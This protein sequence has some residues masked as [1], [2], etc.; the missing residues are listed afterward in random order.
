M[1][2]HHDDLD[3]EGQRLA[4]LTASPRE[5]RRATLDTFHHSIGRLALGT[6]SLIAF[7]FWAVFIAV[8]LTGDVVWRAL[9]VAVAA[10]VGA[11]CAWYG[12]RRGR[13]G[14]SWLGLGLCFAS[15]ALTR[16]LA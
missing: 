9:L 16:L 11:G 8:A 5:R 3:P 10:G 4:F 15:M 12:K 13:A 7:G 2:G 1:L 6:T 14:A